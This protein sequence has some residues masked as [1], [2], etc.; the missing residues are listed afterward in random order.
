MGIGVSICI[1]GL[2]I[3]MGLQPSKAS[4]RNFNCPPGT[5]MQDAKDSKTG[6]MSQVCVRSTKM[7]AEPTS[8]I[9]YLDD[10]EPT[11]S[12][13]TELSTTPTTEMGLWKHILH[14]H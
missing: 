10:A 4:V 14:L 3:T 9:T 12:K 7:F 6:H 11:A 13:V 5:I 1:T 2:Q 8:K